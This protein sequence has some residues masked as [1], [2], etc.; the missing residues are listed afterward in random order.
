M[1]QE[2]P[3][4]PRRTARIIGGGLV[5]IVV[6]AA[7]L[8]LYLGSSTT[9]AGNEET[10]E[11]TPTT[12]TP[13]P[14]PTREA[15]IV[16][17]LVG[18]NVCRE[19]HPGESAQHS[20][21]A[22]ARTLRT[23]PVAAIAAWLDG[24]SVKDREYPEA[25]WT[26]SMTA[27]GK[28]EVERTERG[29]SACYPVDYALG[30]GTNGVTFVSL[31]RAA[32]DATHPTGLEQRISY[33]ANGPRLDITP[34]QI[35]EDAAAAGIRVVPHGRVLGKSDLVK[36]L[37]CH[38][39]ITSA[40]GSGQVD[41]A[42]LVPNISC[43]RCHGPGRAHVEAARRGAPLKEL[44]MPLG[45][46]DGAPLRQVEFCGQCHRRLDDMV[47]SAQITPENTE[48][49]RFQPVGLALSRCFQKG[50]S[51]LACTSCHDPHARVSHDHAPYEAVCLN[52]HSV[53]HQQS[54]P[55][56][57][58]GQC[59]LCHMP[60]RTVSLEFLFTDHWIRI[61]PR[62]QNKAAAQRR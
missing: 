60:R 31:N 2:P 57:P 9:P 50:K 56:S 49:V 21:S 5:A 14:T 59:T 62:D 35:K 51:G 32:G 58:G 18:G 53:V 22:H 40:K 54:C 38:S 16:T 44:A 52:C 45:P 4:E 48:I 17:R 3:D 37:D 28:L 7:C 13:T 19:C 24:R 30:S 11:V 41:P 10:P 46:D 26:F 42:T 61:P 39:T 1:T 29:Q 12:P 6:V 25:V 27:G 20:R 47:S 55:V 43:E 34:G 23:S 8:A 33:F 36:C 15:A